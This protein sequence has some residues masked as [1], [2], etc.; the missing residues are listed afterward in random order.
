MVVIGLTWSLY[1]DEEG[2]ESTGV[3]EEGLDVGG[4]RGNGEEGR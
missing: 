3:G 2:M 4:E 1:V